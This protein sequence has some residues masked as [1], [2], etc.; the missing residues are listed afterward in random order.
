MRKLTVIL[1]YHMS[2]VRL[3]SME[4]SSKTITFDCSNPRAYDSTNF[5]MNIRLKLARLRQNI[6]QSSSWTCSRCTFDNSI[7]QFECMMCD[8]IRI[9]SPVERNVSK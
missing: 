9:I 3:T 7:C 2:I 8:H 6:K 4:D 1:Q 5:E